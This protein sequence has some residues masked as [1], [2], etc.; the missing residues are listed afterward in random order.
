VL[1]QGVT[2]LSFLTHLKVDDHPLGREW[3]NTLS[4]IDSLLVT[5]R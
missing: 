2:P 3:R 1:M 4:I 5:M